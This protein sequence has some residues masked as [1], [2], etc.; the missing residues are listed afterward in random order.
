M[1]KIV[2]HM[3]SLDIVEINRECRREGNS[4]AS[5]LQKYQ[6]F[7]KVYNKDAILTGVNLITTKLTYGKRTW[8]ECPACNGRARFLYWVKD[9]YK[10]R[11][12]HSLVYGSQFY[13]KSKFY[14]NFF[15]PAQRL[16]KIKKLWR[17]KMSVAKRKRLAEEYEEISSQICA[18]L[19]NKTETM[20]DRV[21]KFKIKADRIRNNCQPFGAKGPFKR[22]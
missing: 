13:H 14:D 6:V 9:A 19:N 22:I 5:V 12:C 7:N 1:K 15:K 21:D 10:C 8:F 20:K 18:Y 3:L 16:N 11:K 2:N 4:F 17:K